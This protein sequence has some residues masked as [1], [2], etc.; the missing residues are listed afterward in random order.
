[1]TT[2]FLLDSVQFYKTLWRRWARHRSCPRAWRFIQ[3]SSEAAIGS[4]F[5]SIS[6]SLIFI[7][8]VERFV[9]YSSS[10]VWMFMMEHTCHSSLFVNLYWVVMIQGQVIC[11][12]CLLCHL[13][14]KTTRIQTLD[15][16][17]LPSWIVYMPCCEPSIFIH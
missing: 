15:H 14:G 1:M 4:S 6:N 17:G 7:G 13:C 3:I 11:M 2:T 16:T 10:G 12:P 8:L 9:L 5:D